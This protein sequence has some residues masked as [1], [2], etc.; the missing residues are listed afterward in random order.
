M[1]HSSSVLAVFLFLGCFA[2]AQVAY[3]FTTFQNP[4]A[5]VTLVFGLDNHGGLVGADNHTPGRHAFLVQSG[6]YIPLDPNGVLGTHRSFARGM[7]NR[8]DIVGGY[9]GDDGNEHGFLLRNG[10]LTRLD[11]PFDGSIGTQADDINPSGVIVGVW[12]DG[13]FTVHG[14]VYQDGVYAH[15]DY[16]GAL[17]TAPYGINP[18]G[19]IAGNWD[20]DQST[21][22][23]GFVFRNGQF[24]SLDDPDAVPAGTAANG[25]DAR[26]RIVGGYAG[27]DGNGH[28]F[29]TDGTDF[30]TVDCPGASATTI[31]AINSAGQIAGTCNVTGQQLGFV[32]NPPLM[33]K[34]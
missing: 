6:T 11:V 16:P 21:V 12:V 8:G 23:H 31:W 14:F 20:T 19:D 30:T 22:G 10:A 5:T 26:G 33:N 17:D 7:N 3:D 2:A 9:F 4:G 25:I 28:G 15:L 13:A 34:P 27:L 1:K 29:I 24:T 32:A 18:Q